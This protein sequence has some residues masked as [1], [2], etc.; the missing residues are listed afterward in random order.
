MDMLSD[1]PCRNV[2]V[3]K[4][5]AKEKEIYTIEEL[6]QIFELLDEEDVPVKYRVFFKLAVF[7]AAKCLVWSGKT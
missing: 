5:E 4:G 1:N 7:V 6:A 3:P 2:T